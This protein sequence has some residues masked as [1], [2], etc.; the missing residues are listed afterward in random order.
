MSNTVIFSGSFNPVH[1]GHL[2]IANYVAEFTGAD[3]LLFVVSPHNPFKERTELA[4][5]RSRFDMVQLAFADLQLPVAVSDVES[6]LS[7]PSYTVN[8]LNAL[9]EQRP[10][11]RL[12]LLVGSDCLDKFHLWKDYGTILE[13]YGLL[14]YPRPGFDNADL[15]AK[16][17]AT[18]LDAPLM[19]IS[20][21]FIRDGIRRG[22]NL[23]AFLPHGV[24]DYI[25]DSKLYT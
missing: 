10:D 22:R 23:R 18:L 14:V 16:Y 12:S 19:E 24:F 5:F 11:S 7:Q 15:C 17:C 8:T 21:T 4:D 20:S 6:R 9:S 3:E 1:I 2:A 13:R 25:I